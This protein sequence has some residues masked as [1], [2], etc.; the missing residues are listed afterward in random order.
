MH[1][2]ISAEILGMEEHTTPPTELL[3]TENSGFHGY[4]F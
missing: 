4:G 3:S 1:V 2:E